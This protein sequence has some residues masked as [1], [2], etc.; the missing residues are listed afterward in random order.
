M[1]PQIIPSLVSILVGIIA[2]AWLWHSLPLI[3]L[4]AGPVMVVAGLLG[5]WILKPKSERVITVDEAKKI[6]PI[7]LACCIITA[8]MPCLALDDQP[9]IS[10]TEIDPK[11][12][13]IKPMSEEE[14][15]KLKEWLKRKAKD[16]E[17]EEAT[18]QTPHHPRLRNGL[19]KVLA[20]AFGWLD[21]PNKLERAIWLMLTIIPITIVIIFAIRSRTKPTSQ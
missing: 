18:P 16:K 12:G 2:G 9:A 20:A 4:V 6:I 13:E 19:A 3:G 11:T 17:Q 8:P 14:F 1:N 10:P 5:G 21:A 7:F 15:G